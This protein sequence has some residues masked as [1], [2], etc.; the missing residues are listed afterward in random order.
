MFQRLWAAAAVLAVV[1]TP[2]VSQNPPAAPPTQTRDTTKAAPGQLPRP[3]QPPPKVTVTTGV[4]NPS[5][6][7]GIT[8][9][10]TLLAGFRWRNIGPANMGGRVSS[11]TGIP[12]PSKTFFVAAAAGGIWKTTNAGTTFRPVFDNEKCV[13]M[14]EVA[15]AP[16]DTMQVWA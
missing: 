16:S 1:A 9:D 10:S 6:G 4:Q 14:G 7:G 12:S 13:A 3:Q 8:L 15:I 5:A 2:V 11:V